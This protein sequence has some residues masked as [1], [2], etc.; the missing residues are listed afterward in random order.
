M[1]LKLM[2]GMFFIWSPKSLLAT[3]VSTNL[4]MGMM[5]KKSSNELIKEEIQSIS[6]F[7]PLFSVCIQLLFSIKDNQGHIHPKAYE[8]VAKFMIITLIV[9]SIKVINLNNEKDNQSFK[10][11][12]N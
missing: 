6:N 4:M 11:M 3:F 9:S 12:G 7:M 2:D 8:W 10:K 1:K 5:A